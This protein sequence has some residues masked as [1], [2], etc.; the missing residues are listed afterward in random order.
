MKPRRG[1]SIVTRRARIALS[2]LALYLSASGLVTF[3]LFIIEESIQTAMFGTW[4]AS[5]AGDW[6]T[7]KFAADRISD[8][9]RLLRM[10]NIAGGWIQ[11][12]SFLAY[13]SYGR[14]TEAYLAA[15]EAKLLAKA[16]E[17]FVGR[18]V[19]VS[20]TALEA[21]PVPSGYAHT[22]HRLTVLSP[23]RHPTG[24]RAASPAWFRSRAA[25]WSS[26]K[27]TQINPS[28]PTPST[29][30]RPLVRPPSLRKRSRQCRTP[31]HPDWIS[32]CLE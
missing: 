13:R 8:A 25:R 2:V 17:L 10:I 23:I 3:S 11:P 19:T 32:A 1:R 16:P 27:P 4:Q 5:D 22:N 29:S 7:V 14:A 20:F 18:I 24:S 6:W 30:I 12:L 21:R 31:R 28:P 15:L 26:P 9:N